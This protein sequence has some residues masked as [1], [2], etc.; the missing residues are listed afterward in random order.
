MTPAEGGGNSSRRMRTF[1][2]ILHDK[3]NHRNILEVKIARMNS[4]D[5]MIPLNE[6]DI[7]KFLLNIIGINVDDCERIA[8]RMSK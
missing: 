8:L 4:R 5:I 1:A 6:E 7:S 3:Q 2:E